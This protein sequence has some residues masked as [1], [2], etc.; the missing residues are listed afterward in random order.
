M[1][2]YENS[3]F[4]TETLSNLFTA[5]ILFVEHR[6]FGESMPFGNQSYA[7]NSNIAYLTVT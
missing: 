2:F 3:G 4:L 1:N 5:K 7:N 6:F